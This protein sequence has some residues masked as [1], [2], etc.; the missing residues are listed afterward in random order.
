MRAPAAILAGLML[1]GA[2]GGN[3]ELDIE[4]PPP[5]QRAPGDF[6]VGV[7]IYSPVTDPRGLG[8]LPPHLRPSRYVLEPDGALRAQ[9][10]PGLREQ[11]YPPRIRQLSGEQVDRIWRLVADSPFANRAEPTRIGGPFE[12]EPSPDRTDALIYVADGESRR[13]YRVNLLGASEP[14]QAA[15]ELIDRLARLAWVE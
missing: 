12:V 6:A 14:S 11:D 9:V 7:T 2:C 13:F 4:P 3:G 10:R 15:A 1:L 5:R 8:D